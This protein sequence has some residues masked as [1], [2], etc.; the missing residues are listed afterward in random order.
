MLKKEDILRRFRQFLN[1]LKESFKGLARNL[2]MATASMISIGAM[3]TLFG[4]VFLLLININ[5]AV[6][7]LGQELDKVVVYI[8]DD[9]TTQQIDSLM[10]EIIKNEKV[11]E[12]QFTSKEKAL[13]NFKERLGEKG[14]LI[15]ALNENTL[16]ASL[17]VSL[18]DLSSA[19]E[20]AKEFAQNEIVERADYQ[21][22]LI[23]KMLSFENTIKYAG[24]AIVLVLFLVSILIIH[25]TIRIA[26]AN[27]SH[28]INIMKYIGASDFYIR[29]PFLI[30]GIIFGLVGAAVA[31]FIVIYGYSFYYNKHNIQLTNLLEIGLINPD[32]LVSHIAVI[33][34][35]IGVGIGYLGS[36]VS[37]KRHLNV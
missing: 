16:P 23:E 26:V 27:R 7:N 8:K 31:F 36:L 30:E 25:N 5:S 34:A 1:I 12:V 14:Y 11:R 13:E 4:V 29:S 28:E 37:T 32:L 22:E 15:D 2:G 35:C 6:Y 20:M 33:F 3:L 18:N 24:A 21:Y 9:A 10:N 19:P 17:M